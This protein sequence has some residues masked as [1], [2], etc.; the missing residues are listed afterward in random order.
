MESDTV[1]DSLPE[2]LLLAVLEKLPTESRLNAGLVCSRWLRLLSGDY[3]G[4]VD[5]RL[6]VEDGRCFL[7]SKFERIGPTAAGGIL[8]TLTMCQCME[9]TVMHGVLIRAVL[10]IAGAS[11]KQVILED[12]LLKEY[13]LSSETMDTILENCPNLESLELHD[14]DLSLVSAGTLSK[15]I[16]LRNLKQLIFDQCCQKRRGSGPV[17]SDRLLIGVSAR[18]RLRFVFGFYVSRAPR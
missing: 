4:V 6:V 10:G 15:L 12:Y 11:I 7:T 5:L 8:M 18:G 3:G 1:L 16:R 14:V 9:H 13:C 2:E 17:L